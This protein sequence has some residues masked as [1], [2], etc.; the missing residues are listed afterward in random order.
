M[1]SSQRVLH[2]LCFSFSFFQAK[3][4]LLNQKPKFKSSFTLSP[5]TY[6]PQKPYNL[7]RWRRQLRARLDSFPSWRGPPGS[8]SYATT[9]RLAGH[10]RLWD[11][12]GTNR[13]YYPYTFGSSAQEIIRSCRCGPGGGYHCLVFT[14]SPI[15]P[16][17]GPNR[18]IHWPTQGSIRWNCT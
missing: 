8:S 18:S 9:R 4:I 11:Y 2:F 15:S 3:A 1:S 5:F 13:Q 16:T 10:N 14:C 7:C 17:P 12:R 6:E